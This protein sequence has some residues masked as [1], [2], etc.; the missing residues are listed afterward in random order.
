MNPDRLF[1]YLDGRL[2]EEERRALEEELMSNAEA[3]R[4]FDVARRIHSATRG[5]RAPVE[6]LDERRDETPRGRLGARQILLATLV[7]VAVNVGLG[8]LYIAQ[9]ESTNPNRALLEKQNREQLRQALNNAAERNL[10]APSLGVVQFA[11]TAEPGRAG[12]VAEE[13]V[14]LATRLNGKATKGIPDEKG[15][16]VLVEMAAKRAGEFRA[17]LANLGRMKDANADVTIPPTTNANENVSLVVQVSE[18]R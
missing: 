7:L 15:V 1:D 17:A 16:Q 2:S 9:N 8:L 12:S 14:Q 11:V 3:R 10:T 13:I 5:A 18:A 6:V 4:E